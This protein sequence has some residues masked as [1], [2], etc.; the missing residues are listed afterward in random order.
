MNSRALGLL[1]DLA[2]HHLSIEIVPVYEGRCRTT[3]SILSEP[4]YSALVKSRTFLR[5]LNDLWGQVHVTNT[6]RG[7]QAFLEVCLTYVVVLESRSRCESGLYLPEANE[8]VT[9]K[10]LNDIGL[11]KA[12]SNRT[13]RCAC[14][15]STMASLV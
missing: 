3:N 5:P 11:L 8:S 6:P 1:A 15:L 14:L 10:R 13:R 9:L 12:S 4:K 7:L 2:R